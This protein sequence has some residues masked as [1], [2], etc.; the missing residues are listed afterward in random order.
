MVAEVGTEATIRDDINL[1]PEQLLEILGQAN[2]IEQGPTGFHGDQHIDVALV[3]CLT[4][5]RRAEEAHVASPMGF[6]Q[7]KNLR[8]VAGEKIDN[9]HWEN[10]TSR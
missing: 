6:G 4:A 10:F 5:R 3:A 2:E 8:S 9:V 7:A 1:A